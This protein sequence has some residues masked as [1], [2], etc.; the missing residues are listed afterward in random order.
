MIHFSTAHGLAG[1]AYVSLIL[2][3]CEK[4]LSKDGTAL[5]KKV[6]GTLNVSSCSSPMT[7]AD[8]GGG[9]VNSL[10]KDL[11]E[12]QK[13][14]A[15]SDLYSNVTGQ[16]VE[17][18]FKAA[19]YLAARYGPFENNYAHMKSNEAFKVYLRAHPEYFKYDEATRL[20]IEKGFKKALTHFQSE[21]RK[22]P[23]QPLRVD[24]PAALGAYTDRIK[25]KVAAANA[26][27][28]AIHGKAT[29]D[30]KRVLKDFT[31]TKGDPYKIQ[32]A[33]TDATAVNI[34]AKERAEGASVDMN[35]LKNSPK[36]KSALNDIF[37]SD[38][39]LLFFTDTF[40]KNIGNLKSDFIRNK[41]VGGNGRLFQPPAPAQV[42]ASIEDLKTLTEQ[43]LTQACLDKAYDNKNI[44][45]D[46]KKDK[47]KAYLESNPQA[48]A[49]V[50]AAK[51]N[52]NQAKAACELVQDIDSDERIHGHVKTGLAV[53]GVGSAVALGFFSGGLAAPV[54]AGIAMGVTA[55]TAADALYD[56]HEASRQYEEIQK[57]A[58][59]DQIP[60]EEG[61]T[62][63]G[64]QKQKLTD[65][66]KDLAYTVGGEVVGFGAGK[67]AGK[68]A[69]ESKA[70]ATGAKETRKV[71]ELVRDPHVNTEQILREN[72][73]FYKKGTVE[74]KALE[75]LEFK[76][77]KMPNDYST[78]VIERGYDRISVNGTVDGKPIVTHYNGRELEGAGYISYTKTTD[79]TIE[80]GWSVVG[81]E[82]R[83]QDVQNLLFKR[84]FEAH[85]EVTKIRT[86]LDDVNLSS[87][88]KKMTE[89]IKTQPN[90]TSANSLSEAGAAKL[91]RKGETEILE[92]NQCCANYFN[93]LKKTNPA[94]ARELVE[95]ALK[96]TPAWKT[97]E[98]FGFN[99]LDGHFEYKTRTS[100]DGA[101]D[102]RLE[103]DAV[104]GGAGKP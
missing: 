42:K 61:M 31:K 41:C 2:N 97:R 3:E 78:E 15:I 45:S 21:V 4:N 69:K 52:A 27:C 44:S 91:A 55:G 93:E 87:F 7:S 54:V 81:D 71:S 56:M 12:I 29:E 38:S 43:E 51:G 48:V 46:D 1:D 36:L 83:G 59:T 94:K 96:G 25:Q 62:S 77:G 33:R 32:Y 17:N 99:R 68:L 79:D 103:F 19:F 16:A 63:M 9:K 6:I 85:P 39:G 13:Q 40:Q 95:D 92:F 104:K 23:V 49:G 18:G 30:R 24:D 28:M 82:Y 64:D 8:P 26:A 101:T 102:L 74:Q 50:L 5:G 11:N 14:Q 47:L 88:T 72:P 57:S 86:H 65:A 60:G 84:V 67:I 37:S 70:A 58:A 34:G 98:K 66:Q 22:K 53:A 20:K 73:F 35:L 90:F 89:K 10:G 100:K 76:H 75:N 80:I